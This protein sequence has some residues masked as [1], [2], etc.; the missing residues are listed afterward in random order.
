MKNLTI[1]AIALAGVCFLPQTI[2]AQNITPN[3]TTNTDPET[4]LCNGV[5]IPEEV[6]VNATRRST[7]LQT[8][9]VAVTALSAATLRDAGVANIQDLAQ[10]APSLQVPQ[11]ENAGSVTARIRG[12]GTQ[13]SNPGLESSVGVVIDG[14]FRARNG[15]A[16]SDLGQLEAVEV[17][18]GAQ[19]TLFGRNT[20]AG[21]I[22]VST[23][24]PRFEFGT[25]GDV[26]FGNFGL[27]GIGLGV[28]GPIIKDKIAG[29]IYASA[30]TRDGIL[31]MNEG[32]NYAR[33]ENDKDYFGIRGQL[34]F[35][36]NDKYTGRLIADYAVKNDSCCGSAVFQTDSR[37]PAS[38]SAIINRLSPNGKPIGNSLNDMRGTANLPF[39]QEVIDQGISYEANI[40]FGLGK[41][42]SISAYR[43]WDYLWDQDADFGGADLLHR[44]QADGNGSNYKNF[45]QEFRLSGKANKIDWLFGAFYSHEDLDSILTFH[46]STQY[47]SYIGALLS[48]AGAL[49]NP[50]SGFAA[51]ARNAI[52]T[53]SGG[54]FNPANEAFSY[55][56]GQYDV[57]NQKAESIALFT[58]NIISLTDALKLTIGA[59][60]TQEQ[61]DFK[62][63]YNTTGN[64]GCRALEGVYGMNPSANAPSSAAGAV[65][66]TCVPWERSTLDNLNHIQKFEDDKWSGIA[67]LSYAI[68]EDINAYGSFSRGYKAGGFNLERVFSDKNGSIVSGAIG[69]QIIRAPDTSFAAETVEGFEIGL[70]TRWLNRRLVTNIAIFDQKFENFQLNTYNGISFIVAS[71]PEVNS[72][73]F[74]LDFNWR[75]PINGLNLN[76][77]IAYAK[78]TYGKNLG[79]ASDSNSFIGQ[80]PNLYYLPGAQ[81]TSSPELTISGGFSHNHAINGG[82]HKIKTYFDARYTS[83]YVV[84]SNLDPRKKVGEMVLFGGKIALANMA[85]N[86]AIEVWGKNLGDE[87]YAQII[88]DSPLQ[89][90][91]PLLVNSGGNFVPRGI[92]SQLDAFPAEPRT[93]GIT[94]R[95]NY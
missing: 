10:I 18:R 78:T 62:G 4:C 1:K 49:T 20:S 32:T 69:A 75:T 42:T 76:G 86:W 3:S 93:Y 85:E 91:S 87:K 16:F 7:S 39:S 64:A 5:Q 72:K 79:S 36:P 61:K 17:L 57:F 29:R 8:T 43:K 2:S 14:V 88:F 47:E 34:L 60:Y 65:S 48:G 53:A 24:K 59:R 23:K 33:K 83:D 77:G 67:T 38:T 90:N 25:E 40:D 28:T 70:K 51:A 63:D 44:T 82:R 30:R 13:G 71:V 9:A 66:I 50:V 54:A 68:N 27:A 74:E 58:H 26:G 31:S 11:S 55:G 56:G 45:T 35:T 80:N 89:G 73:G 92:T 95:W 41:F 21:L 81:L 52:A 84:G 46:T 15:V 12:I 37:V 6:V 19:G 22:N 94:L